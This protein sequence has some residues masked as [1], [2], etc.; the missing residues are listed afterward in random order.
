MH[1]KPEIE[2][3]GT[4]DCDLVETTPIVFEG[5][6]IRFET[7][8]TRYRSNETGR[9]FFR[10]LDVDSAEVLTEFA[11]GFELGCAYVEGD[12]IYAYGVHGWGG[13]EIGVFWTSDLERW[14][15]RIGLDLATWGVYNTSVCRAGDRYIMAIELGEPRE[16]VGKRFTIFFAESYDLK[17]WRML[18][19]DRVF[20][21]DRYTACPA[22]RY[23]DGRFY[24]VYL[25]AKPG[26]RYEPHVVRSGDLLSWE[27]SPLNP[28][29]SPSEEDR[30]TANP[31]LPHDLQ[32]RIGNAVNINNSDVDFCEYRGETVI[33]YSWG[34]QKGIEFLAEARFG[35]TPE[36]L[37]TGFFQE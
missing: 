33:N 25:E 12:S 22:I 8:R 11:P 6:L 4:V 2:K 23:I 31:N 16:L 10:L 17:D 34:N 35:G 3:R 19:L 5:R 18:P 36:E 24:M 9:P 13:Q 27:E 30:R 29:L 28:F 1:V 14:D 21:R 7:I 32:G 20:S 15:S 26:P 37:L